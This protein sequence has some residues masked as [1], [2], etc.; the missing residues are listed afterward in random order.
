M[1]QFWSDILRNKT[2]KRRSLGPRRADI[3]AR[4]LRHFL[5]H[6]LEPRR[7]DADQLLLH[8]G[9]PSRGENCILLLACCVDGMSPFHPPTFSSNT[10]TVQPAGDQ[11]LDGDDF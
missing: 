9:R 5:E 2:R 4:R 7:V 8:S 11:F 3:L 6:A 1:P 10:N